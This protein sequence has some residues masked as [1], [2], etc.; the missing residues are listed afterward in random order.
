MSNPIPI[1][2]GRQ[3]RPRA[4]PTQSDGSNN[5]QSSR[6]SQS[7]N[8]SGGVF[9]MEPETQTPPLNGNNAQRGSPESQFL[10]Q[11]PVTHSQRFLDHQE[12]THRRGRGEPITGTSSGQGRSSPVYAPP[13]YSA[14][15]TSALHGP[16]PHTH[17][18]G[19]APILYQPG[20]SPAQRAV[21][22]VGASPPHYGTVQPPPSNA[23]RPQSAPGRLAFQQR[24][25][26]STLTSAPAPTS[27]R[28]GRDFRAAHAGWSAP[29]SQ[30][31]SRR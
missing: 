29:P 12:R 31:P 5:S 21:A 28:R 18:T 16:P 2:P 26:Q 22:Q 13:P 9:R 7:S 14:H 20:R 10:Y 25:E 6:D 24:H 15:A 30:Q 19:Q 11:I 4:S 3:R 27:G 1:P 17:H 23:S 8:V